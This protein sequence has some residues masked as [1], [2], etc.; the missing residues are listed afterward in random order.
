MKIT[1]PLTDAAVLG[2]V[3]ERLSRLRLDRNVTQS[4]LAAQA[5]V[6]KRTVERME[7]GESVQLSSFI[8][9]CRALNL[10]EHFE[11]LVPT[12]ALSPIAQVKLQG[13]KRQRAVK[14]AKTAS[15]KWT[16]GPPQ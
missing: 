3:G 7:A 12:P 4:E 15:E 5:G 1:N 6:S 9:L 10:L 13:K 8:R 16:W 14:A 2:E 11:A